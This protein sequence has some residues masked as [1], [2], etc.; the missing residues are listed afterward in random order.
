M[1]TKLKFGFKL[2]LYT[3][4]VTTYQSILICKFVTYNPPV[5][6]REFINKLISLI[7]VY[8]KEQEQKQQ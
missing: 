3:K 7:S 2:E 5:D 1:F 4:L 8:K 6:I